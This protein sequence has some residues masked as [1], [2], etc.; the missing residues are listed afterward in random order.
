MLALVFSLIVILISNWR[1]KG[2]LH[3]LGDVI[4]IWMCLTWIS[5]VILGI[6]VASAIWGASKGTY[7]GLLASISNF[8]FPLRLQ[9]VLMETHAIEMEHMDDGSH[10]KDPTA[11][12]ITNAQESCQLEAMEAAPNLLKSGR[13][14]RDKWWVLT[15]GK[16][17]RRRWTEV[18]RRFLRNP[19]M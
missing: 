2:P 3:D 16:Y 11:D 7:Y 10:S 8:I 6:P 15:G 17:M 14:S 9:I 18:L 12:W 5:T 19:F 1:K 13:E 4:L